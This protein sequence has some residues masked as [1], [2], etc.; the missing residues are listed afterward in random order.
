VALNAGLLFL[1]FLGLG[2][3]LVFVD[4]RAARPRPAPV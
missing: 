1:A 4:R 3:F 2:L